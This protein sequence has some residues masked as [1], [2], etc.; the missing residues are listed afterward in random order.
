MRER[1]S[2]TRYKHPSPEVLDQ[3]IAETARR[4]GGGTFTTSDVGEVGKD[5]GYKVENAA[6][7]A[8]LT[9]ILSSKYTPAGGLFTFK[10]EPPRHRDIGDKRDDDVFG[11]PTGSVIIRGKHPGGVR[12][13]GWGRK[14]PGRT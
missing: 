7:T 5:L 12:H 9:E 14:A 3:I 2:G 8:E 13:G 1:N 11:G 6:T 4:A 10:T